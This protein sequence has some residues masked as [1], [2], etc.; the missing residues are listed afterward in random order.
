MRSLERQDSVGYKLIE[1]IGSSNIYISLCAASLTVFTQKV[2]LQKYDWTFISITFCATFLLYNVQRMYLSF[3]RHKP[4]SFFLWKYRNK[5]IIILMMLVSAVGLLP[6][7]RIS[8]GN[9]VVYCSSFL[10]G[11]FYFLPFSNWRAIPVIKSFTVGAVWGLVGVAAPLEATGWNVSRICFFI[12]QVIFIAALCVLF[13]IR[14]MEED[15]KNNTHSVP[16]L[17]GIKRT[18][19]FNY[20]LLALYLV[21]MM[22]S[23]FS[24]SILSAIVFVVSC[25]LTRRSGFSS[26]P[27]FYTFLVDGVILLQY[28]LGILLI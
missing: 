24:L 20:F 11:V 10:L 5:Y 8:V 12:A 19:Q 13:N 7:L 1:F 26:H 25:Y 22:L 16:V 17:F 27:F 9:V 21:F 4:Y 28:A 6:M 15:R 2:F 3:F 23:S 18:Q 14:D